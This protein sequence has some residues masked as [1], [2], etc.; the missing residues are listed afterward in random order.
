MNGFGHNADE[1][2]SGRTVGRKDGDPAVASA[3]PR[4]A[5]PG[6]QSAGGESS[7]QSATQGTPQTSQYGGI[8]LPGQTPGASGESAAAVNRAA[9]SDGSLAGA[10]AAGGHATGSNGSGQRGEGEADSMNG[11]TPS[12][13]FDA[14]PPS[15]QQESQQR[16][17][18]RSLAQNR[19]TNWALPS[20]NTSSVPIQRPIRIECWNDR[21]VLLPDTR[22]QQPQVI[23]LSERTDEAVDQLV[24]AV[25]AYTK[26]WGM[27]G[28]G[29]Y[30]KPQLVLQ[31]DGNA[32]ARAADLQVLLADS[33]WDVKRK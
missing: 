23:P 29:M 8:D 9:R 7:N 16:R 26:T 4:Y 20:K 15:P 21:L 25:R 18:S 17:A 2:G 24:D 32:Q 6:G 12:L 14:Q 13:S 3:G 5:G 33:G 28:R 22:D 1:T 30:W 19:G 10:P 31:V 27:A 11:G